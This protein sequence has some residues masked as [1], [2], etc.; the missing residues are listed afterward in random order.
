MRLARAEVIFGASGVCSTTCVI[1][2]HR[3]AVQYFRVGLCPFSGHVAYRSQK[4][5][6]RGRRTT[7][8]YIAC[9]R[10][11][12]VLSYLRQDLLHIRFRAPMLNNTKC[13]IKRAR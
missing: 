2:L 1:G 11:F 12:T 10:E 8:F 6:L 7:Q 9:N 3:F 13:I 4:L 5:V